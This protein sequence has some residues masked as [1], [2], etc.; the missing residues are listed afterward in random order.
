M[1]Q[2]TA[3]YRTS[4]YSE[5][6]RAIT[7]AAVPH[8]EPPAVVRRRRIIVA[9]TIVLGAVVLGFSL[10]CHPG[11]SSFYWL[12]FLLAAVCSV[13][14]PPPSAPDLQPPRAPEVDPL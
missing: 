10:R 11:E 5:L 13:G 4:V 9:I 8:N 3:P 14:K 2:S 6:R 7:N 12:T 1:T